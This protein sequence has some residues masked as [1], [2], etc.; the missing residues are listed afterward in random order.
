MKPSVPLNTDLS[1]FAAKSIAVSAGDLSVAV[2]EEV[3]KIIN[4]KE[5]KN[6]ILKSIYSG[7]DELLERGVISEK[8]VKPLKRICGHLLLATLENKDEENKEKDREDAF[9]AIKKLYNEMLADQECSPAALSIASVI[10]SSFGFEK[11]NSVKIIPETTGAGAAMGAIIGA[12]FGAGFGGPIGAGI[13]GA[14]GGI[15]GAAI[16]LSNETGT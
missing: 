11:S 13:G 9:F 12:G 7:L 14:I 1:Y 10:H 8:E 3:R 4:K 2:R 5:N 6:N 16:G 15:V